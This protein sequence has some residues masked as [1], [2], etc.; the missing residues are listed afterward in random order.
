MIQIFISLSSSVEGCRTITI[1]TCSA[2][3]VWDV[4]TKIHGKVGVPP[5]LQCLIN[6][7]K[8]L[9]DSR[10]VGSYPITQDSSLFFILR[11]S[12]TSSF[13]ESN[14]SLPVRHINSLSGRRFT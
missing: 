5:H 10:T 4:K 12:S 11:P 2:D 8:C 7:G 13:V 3:T 14:C 9:A 1:D 6:K